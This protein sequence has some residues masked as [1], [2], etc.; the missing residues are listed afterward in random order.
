MNLGDIIALAWSNLSHRRLRS[1]LTLLGIFAGIAAIVA[2]ISLGQGLQG[3]V[4]GQFAAIG[5]NYFSVQGAGSN[6]G[7]PGTNAV[8]KIT[9]DDVRLLEEIP[10]VEMA[11]G[12]YIKSTILTSQ[13][14]EENGFVGSVAEGE[15]GEKVIELM[16]NKIETGRIITGSDYSAIT[17]GA[18]ITF[19]NRVPDIGEK[20]T[21]NDE[22][23]RV[24]GLLEK[25][26]NP[27]NDNIVLMSERRTEDL[28]DTEE[29]SIIMVSVDENAD[30]EEVR[31]E[32]ERKLRRDRGQD[33]GE[34]DFVI[35]SPQEAL[36]ALNEI[37][38]TVQILLVG[39][40]AISLIVGGI[41]IA[42]TMYT[43]VLERKR[44]IGVM[45]SIGAT[46]NNILSIFLF[47]SGFLGLAGGFIGLLLGIGI[48]KAVEAIV[49]YS[50]GQTLLQATIPAWLIIGSLILAFALGALSGTLPA[51]QAAKLDPVES[52][53]G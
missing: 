26:G 1:W 23:L 36:D 20:V 10:G 18:S 4:T 27:I 2:L 29:Y 8:G 44:E 39:I 17:L 31:D 33:I 16:N 47:E 7:P 9:E 11:I 53:R 49:F 3:A 22:V 21:I 35:S 34:E 38:T 46:N 5:V 37:L 48:S 40:A 32:A 6:F 28:F 41:G 12:R 51:R 45:K 25:T 30:L 24:V 42:N 19:D 13:D 14:I 43:A 50:Y 15:K 52:L